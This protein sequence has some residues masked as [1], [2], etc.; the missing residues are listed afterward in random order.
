[1]AF[2][3]EPNLIIAN[4]E[5]VYDR[6]SEETLELMH[7]FLFPKA[8][9]NPVWFDDPNDVGMDSVIELF[10][11]NRFNNDPAESNSV[12]E[13]MTNNDAPI[14]MKPIKVGFGCEIISALC[15]SIER[16]LRKSSFFLQ[17]I[18]YI[19]ILKKNTSVAASL[20]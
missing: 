20:C 17:V 15:E 9:V 3:N 18:F 12:I 13:Y 6:L 14:G 4:D 5:I 19:L 1:M 7:A 11:G 2:K 8:N 16:L 10:S